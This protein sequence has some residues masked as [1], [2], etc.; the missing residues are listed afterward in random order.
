MRPIT[1]DEPLHPGDV[2][3]HP[4][5]GFA[6]VEGVDTGSLS[7]RWERPGPHHP[8]Q[9]GRQALE[10]WRRCDARGLCA[11]T[12]TNLDAARA[13]LSREPLTALALLLFDLGR[14]QR[15]EDVRDWFTERRLV[16]EHRFDEWWGAVLEMVPQD[17]RFVMK[18]GTIALSAGLTADDLSPSRPIALPEPG[19]LPPTAALG[20]ALSLTQALAEAH[21]LGRCLTAGREAIQFRGDGFLLDTRAGAS[22]QD[23]RDD[24][25]T[26]LR[27]TLEQVL[28]PLPS[29]NDLADGDLPPLVAGL[30]PVLPF[31]LLGVAQE[32]LAN[33]LE[34]RPPDALALLEQLTMAQATA[35]LRQAL[36]HAPGAAVVVGFDTHI[37][38]VKS[39]QGQT[40]Q[41][42]FFVLGE[43]TLAL[44]GVAD[45]ISL[46]SAGTGDMASH[47]TVRSLRSWFNDHAEQ[48]QGAPASK[49]HTVLLEGLRRANRTVCE[50]AMRIANGKIDRHIPM[51]TTVLAALAT[52]NR[53]HLVGMGDSR[54]YVVGRLGAAVA[55]A[56]LNLQSLRLKEA[57]SGRD[58]E[59][60]EP[61]YSLVSYCGHFTMDGRIE[62]PAVTTRTF[63]LLPGE[64]LIL[65]TDGLSDY[66][67]AEEAE[68]CALITATV[69]DAVGPTIG[70]RAMDVARRL[71]E[72]ANRSGGGDNV[73]VLAVT[74]SAEDAPVPPEAPVRSLD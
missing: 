34:L 10:P 36:P 65:A 38:M 13:L 55:S 63:H 33:D 41:D 56:D 51:G 28:G 53:I 11:R 35:E 24:V 25:R 74:L 71:V 23:L 3:H 72:L 17:P 58:V 46:S 26:V 44:F 40:N 15:K 2:L 73:T 47:L 21:A 42:A 22:T 19:T 9:V 16:G 61:R 18:R 66:A 14:P 39:L 52:G 8:S 29:P 54:A 68:T 12:V 4:A 64:W 62:M 27:L 60:D 59:W 5:F 6:I 7:L 32:A 49:V 37:G 20:F 1:N 57:L 69:R 43:P 50:Q 48:L 67:G 70:A 31:E 45:G 30:E